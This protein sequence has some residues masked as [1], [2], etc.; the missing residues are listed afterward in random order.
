M[1]GAREESARLCKK[2]CAELDKIEQFFEVPRGKTFGEIKVISDRDYFN[3]FKAPA[4]S[5][6]FF[7]NGTVLI[8]KS[9]YK[10]DDFERALRH[11]LV[12]LTVFRHFG[13]WVPEWLDEGLALYLEGPPNPNLINFFNTWRASEDRLGLTRLAS[14]I[15]SM[16]KTKAVQAYA[17]SYF[18]VRYLLDG[19]KK[20]EL[21]AYLKREHPQSRLNFDQI[22]RA[23]LSSKAQIRIR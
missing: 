16:P 9:S 3:K 8:P 4:W 22:E 5:N 1:D 17:L 19:G 18:A 6:A 14:G 13:P 7:V 2:A 15:S 21:L 12:H 11:E 23:L 10:A 20:R